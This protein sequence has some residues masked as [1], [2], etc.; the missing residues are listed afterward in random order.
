[1][2]DRL[3][4]LLTYYLFWIVFF[5]LQKPLFMIWQHR[6]LG[7]VAWSDWFLVPWHGLPLD[8]STAAYITVLYGL[9]LVASVWVRWSVI[10]KIADVITALLLTIALWIILGDNGAFP[11][12]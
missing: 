4:L 1:M 6:L 12:W 8:L 11:S 9:L 10:E 7:D 2:K 3:R 5:V